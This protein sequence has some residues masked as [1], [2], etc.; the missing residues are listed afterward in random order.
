MQ[1]I[2]WINVNRVGKEYCKLCSWHC[3]CRWY[4]QV[5]GHLG[6]QCWPSY[7]SIYEE[8]CTCCPF[9]KRKTTFQDI[10][11][12]KPHISFR[13]PRTILVISIVFELKY[14]I[15]EGQKLLM[16]QPIRG[17]EEP[18]CVPSCLSFSGIQTRGVR[19]LCSYIH[20]WPWVRYILCFDHK[21]ATFVWLVYIYVFCRMLCAFVWWYKGIFWIIPICRIQ[22]C[23]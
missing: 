2:T 8:V 7:G 21:L 9:E 18:T 22:H 6:V 20:C 4:C 11:C 19:V 12:W 10:L 17:P 16:G 15:N 3:A 13:K 1:T 14:N 23:G 5:I